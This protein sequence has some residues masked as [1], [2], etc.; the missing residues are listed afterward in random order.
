MFECLQ[1]SSELFTCTVLASV[2]RLQLVI[3]GGAS[4]CTTPHTFSPSTASPRSTSRRRYC[5]TS[6]S[7]LPECHRRWT[8]YRLCAPVRQCR[9][10]SMSLSCIPPSM[11]WITRKLC[12]RL[13]STIHLSAIVEVQ[14]RLCFMKY[15][16]RVS[17]N[18][19]WPFIPYNSDELVPE[20]S[21]RIT[22]YTTFVVLR[23][24]IITP[25]FL[26]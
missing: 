11:R 8:R 24:L 21:E 19:L 22:Q 16:G 12:R 25:S 14:S 23:F 26:S 10:W 5:R 6:T 4:S 3:T 2:T 13:L 18:C 20:I 1:C 17:N 7:C 9:R 15:N